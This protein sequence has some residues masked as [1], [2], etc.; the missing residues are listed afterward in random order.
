[1]KQGGILGPEQGSPGGAPRADVTRLALVGLAAMLAA[2]P[3]LGL[4]SQRVNVG[5]PT[6]RTSVQTLSDRAAARVDFVPVRATV[7]TLVRLRAPRIRPSTPR[8]KGVERTTYEVEARLV[9]ATRSGAGTDVVLADPSSRRT[10]VASFPDPGCSRLAKSARAG[11]VG[12]ALNVLLAECGLLRVGSTARLTGTATIVGVG[13]FGRRRSS[14][15]AAPNGVEL[16]PALG[17]QAQAGCQSP[18]DAALIAAGDIAA[19]PSTG[20]EAT[21]KLLDEL[22]G[23]VAALGDNAY[24]SGSASEYARC[25]APTWGRHKARTRPAAG[26]HEYLT[27][28]AAGYFGYFGAAA[29]DPSKGY[30]SYDLGTWHIA[31]LN[32]QCGAVGGCYPNSPQEHWLRRDLAAHPAMCTLAYWHLPRFSSG[33]YGSY[34]YIQ[35]LWQALY[36]GG[37]DVVLSGHEHDYERFAPQT[38]VGAHDPAHGIREFVVGT[39][40][41]GLFPVG[42]PIAN[43]EVFKLGVHGVLKL[44]LRPGRYIWRFFPAEGT[45]FTDSGSAACH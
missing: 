13:F 11:E 40:G 8:L 4:S 41:A 22:P 12:G 7:D 9:A 42:K 24:P 1:V 27:P 28:G 18:L 16:S 35:P 29:G 44:T 30:Y 36:D 20:A 15:S 43:S 25:Y 32:S 6:F 33:E 23:T 38:P 5:C 10:L 34:S 39:G 2:L 14:R 3:G 37:A 26:N 31:V 17:F 21:A 45:G 19:C